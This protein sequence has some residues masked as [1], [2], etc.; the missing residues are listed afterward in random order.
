MVKIRPEVKKNNVEID[1]E[2]RNILGVKVDSTS[3]TS[4]LRF[5]RSSILGRRKFYIVTPNPE[6]VMQ[7]QKDLDL[8]EILN[9][10][11]VSLPDGIGLAQ[12]QKFLSLPSGPKASTGPWPNP[13]GNI[14]RFL[15]LFV[16]GLGVGFLTI[17]DNQ[18]ITEGLKII[19]GRKMFLELIKLANGKKW[20]VFLLGGE[21][22]ESAGTK[23]E[24]EKSYKAV[25]IKAQAGPIL[26]VEGEPI[27]KRD[28]KTEKN[29]I[30]QINNFNPHLLFVAFKF[31]RQEKWVYRRYRELNIGGAMV[32]GGTFNYISGKA[33]LPPKWFED[34][35]LEWFWR[36]MNE[37]QRGKRILTAFPTFPL[38][39]FWEKLNQ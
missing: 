5:V 7:A 37:P 14:L 36:L 32:V 6:I 39:V 15:A 20:R 2:H 21:G 8:K 18:K 35:G 28:E 3:T 33:K 34:R 38:K 30:G 22:G 19:S 29:V 10:A 17:V 13:K 27:S 23:S 11:D 9:S 31:P 1:R 16:Q 4:V 25:V 24:L 26:N 12:A